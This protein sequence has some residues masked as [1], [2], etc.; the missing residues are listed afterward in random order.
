[1]HL[2]DS[3]PS[4]ILSKHANHV[5]HFYSSFVYD[6]VF[7]VLLSCY[8]SSVCWPVILNNKAYLYYYFLICYHNILYTYLRNITNILMV[9]VNHRELENKEYVRYTF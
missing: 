6:F 5:L 3:A 8:A 2:S 9:I 1:M 4:P 7:V